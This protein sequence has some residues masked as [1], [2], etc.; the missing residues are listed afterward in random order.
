MTSTQSGVAVAAPEARDDVP[1]DGER[2]DPERL[3][4]FVTR[5]GASA[6]DQATVRSHGGYAATAQ[7]NLDQPAL[8]SVR[9][10]PAD[11]GS[12]AVKAPPVAA[13]ES[14]SGAPEPTATKS[15]PSEPSGRAGVVPASPAG[16][17][18]ST[19][20]SEG[21]NRAPTH[22]VATPSATRVVA[23]APVAAKPVRMDATTA[24][25]AEREGL[26]QKHVEGSDGLTAQGGIAPSASHPPVALRAEAT[27]LPAPQIAETLVRH[28]D[29][30][31]EVT[32]NPEELGKVRMALSTA[33]GSLTLTIT[34][35]RQETL[36]LMRR[37]I[38]GLAQEF[39]RMGFDSVGFDFRHAGGGNRG[40]GPQGTPVGDLTE[41]EASEAAA[42]PR[43]APQPQRIAGTGLD[44][45]I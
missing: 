40:P 35:D 21:R 30:G 44:I 29:R 4:K 36:D 6:P 34:G 43:P 7:V 45:R 13:V 38:D 24:V 25:P 32:L 1:R 17:F 31:V 23:E 2:V 12:R 19:R 10:R 22:T 16:P 27:R 28:A 18:H 39:R 5:R 26:F 11:S 14:G 20:Y 41:P 42:A 9:S 3:A 15:V 8:G 33:D 37:H